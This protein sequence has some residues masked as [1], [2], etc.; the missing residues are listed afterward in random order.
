MGA[1]QGMWDRY[2][3]WQWDDSY[4]FRS[5]LL[6]SQREQR[7]VLTDREK[8]T[9]ENKKIDRMEMLDNFSFM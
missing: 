6:E 7:V 1:V 8:K 2:L 5:S 4:Q 9:N 3:R